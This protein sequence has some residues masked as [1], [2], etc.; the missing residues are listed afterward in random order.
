MD[1]RN[2]PRTPY[3]APLAVERK[4][5]LA[6]R[7]DHLCEWLRVSHEPFGPRAASHH[8]AGRGLLADMR[9]QNGFGSHQVLNDVHGIVGPER[10]RTVSTRANVD[11]HEVRA[12]EL[13]DD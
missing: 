8:A 2:L 1:R 6:N 12:V 5:D 4:G 9:W 7:N 10:C 11:D 13:R 3:T